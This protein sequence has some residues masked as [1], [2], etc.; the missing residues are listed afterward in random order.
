[1]YTMLYCLFSQCHILVSINKI[2]WTPLMLQNYLI[3]FFIH[4]KLELLTQF[5]GSTNE[6]CLNLWKNSHLQYWIID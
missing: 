3:L 5:Q 1:M 6:K 2:D 4:L